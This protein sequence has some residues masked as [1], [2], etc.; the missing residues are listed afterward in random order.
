MSKIFALEIRCEGAAFGGSVSTE[1]A[2]I[3]QGVARSIEHGQDLER[4]AFIHKVFDS[5]GNH[6]GRVTFYHDGE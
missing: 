1:V 3:L 4:G 5:N 2:E 6:C